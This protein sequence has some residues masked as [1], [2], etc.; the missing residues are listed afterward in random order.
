MD[1]IRIKEIPLEQVLLKIFKRALLIVAGSGILTN[2][3]YIYGLGYYQGYIEAFSF[4]Y[5]FFSI[6][7]SD[8]IVWTY[9][10]SRELGANLIVSMGSHPFILLVSLPVVYIFARVW[11]SLS[12]IEEKTTS[13]LPGPNGLK[14]YRRKRMFLILKRKYPKTYKCLYVPLAWL[15]AKEQAF[16]AFLASYFFLF[17]IGLLPLFVA[18]WVFLPTVGNHHGQT[19]VFD[20]M[21]RKKEKFCDV[22][23]NG[24][25]PCIT[26]KTEHL[27]TYEKNLKLKEVTG[28]LVL[29]NG[30]YVGIYTKTGSITMTLPKEFLYQNVRQIHR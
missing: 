28:L 4:E 22:E 17:F 7:W 3:M 23:E 29:K 26:I 13:S 18:M 27:N 19:V 20:Y 14:G 30:K 15:F 5:A 8:A 1:A 12:T 2:A 10:A 24:W 21:D 9:Y 16:F 25:S 6:N 11:A